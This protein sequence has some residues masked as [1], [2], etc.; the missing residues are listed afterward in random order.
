MTQVRPLKRG[1]GWSVERRLSR[2]V[3]IEG[4]C[5]IWTGSRSGNGYGM[6]AVDNVRWMAHR[7][8][9]TA[10]VGAI[11]EGLDLD[12]LCRNRACIN[13]AHLEP[14]TRSE[15]LK[16]GAPRGE[17]QRARTHCPHNHPYDEQNTTRRNGRRIC[18]ACDR[19]RA[20]RNRE[21]RRGKD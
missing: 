12:H 2:H 6:I 9:Y 15:N 13:P 7:Y 21:A 4:D 20:R 5:W 14:V 10:L 1:Y 19:D 3:S 8:A 17:R 18:K 16:R 11:P